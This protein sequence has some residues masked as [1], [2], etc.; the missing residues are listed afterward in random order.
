MPPHYLTPRE[1]YRQRERERTNA[2]PRLLDRFGHIKALTLELSHYSAD[3]NRKT[4]QFKYSVNV[5]TARCVFSFECPN[6]YCVDGGFDLSDDI[7][8][9]VA[10][11]MD[12]KEGQVSCQGWKSKAT[13]GSQGCGNQLR[14]LL[15]LEFE[16]QD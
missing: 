12:E 15:N 11:Q 8:D 3:G 9:A 13:V 10:A 5:E 7:R 2:S 14:Y 4:S 16:G 6:E 1:E